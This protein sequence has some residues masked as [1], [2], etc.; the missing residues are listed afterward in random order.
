MNEFIT[1][2]LIG[3]GAG[4]MTATVVGVVVAWLLLRKNLKGWAGWL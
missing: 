3:F 4:V 1:G 2:L